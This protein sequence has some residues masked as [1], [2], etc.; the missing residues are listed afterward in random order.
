[1]SDDIAEKVI[2]ITANVAE[3]VA[4]QAEHVEKVVRSLNKIK[5]QFA[6][7]GAA[8]GAAAGAFIA[9]GVAYRKAETK[10][11][12]ISDDEIAEMRQHYQD[13]ALAL[14]AEASKTDLNDLVAERGYKSPDEGPPMAV[15]PPTGVVE[16]AKEGTESTP[17]NRQL[18]G[19][20]LKPGVPVNQEPKVERH[21]VFE[22]AQHEDEWDYQAELR[23]RSPTEPYVIHYDERAEFDTYSDVTLTYY[24]VDDVLCNERDEIVDLEKREELVGEKNLGKFGHGSNDA[25][26]VFV[27]N[28]TLEI[29]FEVVKSPN[30]Y[31]EEVHG[32]SHDTNYRGNLERMRARERDEP[33]DE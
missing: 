29:E 10:Y 26:I 30:S 13:K 24:E 33:E 18:Q 25:A 9:F 15:S 4:E 20:R 2:D 14:D 27:R 19:D 21:N 3:D 12:K 31:A 28:D 8:C 32:L 5:V 7:L 1:M 6:L 17:N 16:A 11:S 23:R 22:D